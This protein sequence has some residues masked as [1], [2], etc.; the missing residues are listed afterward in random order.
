MRLRKI[1]KYKKCKRRSPIR[2]N[3]YKKS[4]SGTFVYFAISNYKIFIK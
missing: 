2:K 1:K 4:F 3:K